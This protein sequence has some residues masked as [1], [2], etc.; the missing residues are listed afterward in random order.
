MIIF[1]PCL[2][3]G[4]APKG[5]LVSPHIKTHTIVRCGNCWKQDSPVITW[6]G[7]E[8]DAVREW[9]EFNPIS[10]GKGTRR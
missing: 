6:F 1:N 4:E 7:N 8:A 9:N 3:C 10:K 5:L 2:D